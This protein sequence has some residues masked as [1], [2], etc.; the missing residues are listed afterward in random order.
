MARWNKINKNVILD[1]VRG[2]PR[3]TAREIHDRLG[4]CYHTV[5]KYLEILQSDGSIRFTARA[6]IEF[7][8]AKEDDD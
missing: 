5:L 4:Y 8:E 6:G 3:T 7:W 1:D 2:H